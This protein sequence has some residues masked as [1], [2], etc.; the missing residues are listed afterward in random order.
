MVFGSADSTF[1]NLKAKR[2][3]L[4]SLCTRRSQK[5]YCERRAT[6]P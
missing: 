4:Y 2:L 3:I 5:R 6:L 1:G